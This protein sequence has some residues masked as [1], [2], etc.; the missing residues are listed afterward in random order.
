LV[1][2][3]AVTPGAKRKMAR[4]MGIRFV[5]LT[6]YES[7]VIWPKYRKY[8]VRARSVNHLISTP[9]AARRS[10]RI[11][12]TPAPQKADWDSLGT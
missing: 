10:E 2:S 11:K 8:S 12:S 7:S 1:D 4:N 3:G 6:I 5:F 9:D